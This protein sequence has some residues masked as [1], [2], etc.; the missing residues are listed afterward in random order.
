MNQRTSVTIEASSIPVDSQNGQNP[1]PG[2][3]SGTQPIAN[4]SVA[5][6]INPSDTIIVAIAITNSA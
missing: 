3:F 1:E 4:P 6:H 5:D 2:P